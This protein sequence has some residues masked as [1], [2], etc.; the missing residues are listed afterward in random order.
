LTAAKENVCDLFGRTVE[1][2]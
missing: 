1:D 2:K